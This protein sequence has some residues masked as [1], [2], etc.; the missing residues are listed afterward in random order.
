VRR[1]V[2]GGIHEQAATPLPVGEG[3]V[4]DF[5]EERPDG[6]SR[7]AARL[8][9]GDTLARRT[10]GVTLQGGGK[11]GTLAAVGVVEA[12]T[13]DSHLRGEVAHRGR[14]VPVL[15]EAIDGPLDGLVFVELSQSSHACI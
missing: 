5:S 14:L 13:T 1:H 15:P 4:D 12:G 2:E 10:V 11:E 7:P 9:T 6:L 3:P 8:E